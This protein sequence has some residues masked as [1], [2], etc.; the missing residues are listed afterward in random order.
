MS[1]HLLILKS[2]YSKHTLDPNIL[3]LFVLDPAG[4]SLLTTES[5]LSQPRFCSRGYYSSYDI[6]EGDRGKLCMHLLGQ[7]GT[8]G[9]YLTLLGGTA[10]G[11]CDAYNHSSLITPLF[12]PTGGLLEY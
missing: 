9:A 5:E 1:L 11:M 4:I 8:V 3:N 6:Q 2:N 10:R 12:E 7:G